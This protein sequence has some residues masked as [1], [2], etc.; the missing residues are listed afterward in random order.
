MLT[1]GRRYCGPNG[2]SELERMLNVRSVSSN[3]VGGTCS[4]AIDSFRSTLHTEGFAH[5]SSLI[6]RPYSRFYKTIIECTKDGTNTSSGQ[7]GACR[8]V[9]V[10]DNG[11]DGGSDGSA[12]TTAAGRARGVVSADGGTFYA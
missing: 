10:P 6:I 3:I 1:T 4:T 12:L 9:V 7:S 11:N 2:W 5:S 8:I